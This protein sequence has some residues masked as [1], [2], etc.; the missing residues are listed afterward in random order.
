MGDIILE[1]G[2]PQNVEGRLEK[3][4]VVYDFLDQLGIRYW[5]TDH[6]DAEA[7]TMEACKESMVCLEQPYVRI[8]F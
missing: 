8:F 4:V 1:E 3:E 2:R 5:R 7:Y 6:P